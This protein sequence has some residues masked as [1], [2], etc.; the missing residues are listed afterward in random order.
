MVRIFVSSLDSDNGS[1][2]LV[3]LILTADIT[4]EDINRDWR[5]KFLF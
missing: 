5:N 2:L 4:E 3:S 1:L